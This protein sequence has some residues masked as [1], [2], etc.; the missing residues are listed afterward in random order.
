VQHQAIHVCS[1]LGKQTV[2]AY[3]SGSGAFPDL[4]QLC[5][6]EGRGTGY[7]DATCAIVLRVKG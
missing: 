3:V 6:K 2:G 7:I 1:V 5:D 4:V